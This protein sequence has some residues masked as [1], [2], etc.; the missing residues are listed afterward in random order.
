L[1][2]A[3]RRRLGPIVARCLSIRRAPVARLPFG[4][5]VAI[6]RTHRHIT[7]NPAEYTALRAATRPGDV[8]LDLGA[9]V[10][11]Y[12]V[13]F[14]QWVGPSGHVYAFE[15]DARAA[16]GLRQHIALNRLERRVTPIE[17][18]V[19]DR[20]S[21]A[22]PFRRGASSGL[23]RVVRRPPDEGAVD[24]VPACSI[25][26]FCERERV[27]PAVMK[28][29]VEGSELRALAGARRTIAAAGSRLAIFVEM[30]PALWSESGDDLQALQHECER[31]RLVPEPIDGSR[32]DVWTTEGICVRLRRRE[33]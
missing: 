25:D 23:G 1:A 30:H 18:A 6:A 5:Q 33:P 9:N 16:A 24:Y 2:G 13:L 32:A 28:I 10:G 20:G 8:V 7:W 26:E 21:G 22:V 14:G 3:V 19:L 29:D 11:A 27:A 12:A 17:R 31:Q 4:E 15:P